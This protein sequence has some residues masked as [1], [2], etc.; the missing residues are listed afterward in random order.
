MHLVKAKGSSGSGE[1]AQPTGQPAESSNNASAQ[2]NAQ[3]NPFGGFGGMGGMG[4]MPG[5]PGMGGF[6]GMGGMG[7]MPDPAM[8]Q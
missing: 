7:G 5:M 8:M 1:G 6:G 2:P 4:G 3:A